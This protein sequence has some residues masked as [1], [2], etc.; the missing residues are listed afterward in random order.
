MGPKALRYC[1]AWNASRQSRPNHRGSSGTDAPE[2]GRQRGL[3]LGLEVQT[4]N[5]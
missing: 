5:P 2:Q 3:E 4:K 1:T